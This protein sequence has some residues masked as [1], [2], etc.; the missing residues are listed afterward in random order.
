MTTT[1][2][3]SPARFYAMLMI[4]VGLIALGIMLFMLLNNAADAL[5]DDL[6]TVPA[7]VNFASPELTLTDLSG[8]P[9]SLTDHLGSVVLV[10]LWATWCPPCKDEMPSLQTFYENHKADGFVLIGIDQEET[11]EVVAPFVAE[12][13]LTFPVWLDENYLAQR[14]FNTSSLPSSYVIDRTG[15]VRLMWVGG[16]SEKFLEKYVTKLIKE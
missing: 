14:E 16:I 13:G 15:N 8:N 7:Q 11:L 10:N 6:S 1:T 2:Q 9:V 5:P 4:G 12:F 3:P